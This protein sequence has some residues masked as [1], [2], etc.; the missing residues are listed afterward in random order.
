MLYFDQ[1]TGKTFESEPSKLLDIVFKVNRDLKALKTIELN[2][3]LNS[4]YGEQC[5]ENRSN[6]I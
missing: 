2:D 3:F 6:G 1:T 4:I 5:P